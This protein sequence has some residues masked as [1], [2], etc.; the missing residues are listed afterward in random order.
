MKLAQHQYSGMFGTFLFNN[1]WEML[2]QSEFSFDK[3]SSDKNNRATLISVFDYL[4]KQ[5]PTFNN[6][7]YEPRKATRLMC[8]KRIWE[9]QIWKEVY[10]LTSAEENV[11]NPDNVCHNAINELSIHGETSATEKLPTLSRSQSAASLNSLEQTTN[12]IHWLVD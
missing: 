7:V 8:P 9:L 1:N 11:N 10:C 2:K 5:N 4:N 6:P 3:D 12:G